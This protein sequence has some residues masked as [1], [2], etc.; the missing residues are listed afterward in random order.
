M[1]S[2]P[3]ATLSSGTRSGV[4]VA[5]CALGGDSALDVFYSAEL[6]DLRYSVC[7]STH[8][9]LHGEI[10]EGGKDDWKA[11][12]QFCMRNLERATERKMEDKLCGHDS[13]RK[14]QLDG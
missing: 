11:C 2:G 3:C 12:Q 4:A 5:G 7:N 6:S 8:L 9:G 14:H 13:A 10:S 1:N